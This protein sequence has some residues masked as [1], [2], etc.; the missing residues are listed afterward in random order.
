MP[1]ASE[2]Y[3]LCG[4]LQYCTRAVNGVYE[5][6]QVSTPPSGRAPVGY[7]WIGFGLLFNRRLRRFHSH[8]QVVGIV[9]MM[10]RCPPHSLKQAVEAE[11]KGAWRPRIG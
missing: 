4:A 2:V 10:Y 11:V 1:P 3:S 9:G 6:G 5:H 8:K 7:N